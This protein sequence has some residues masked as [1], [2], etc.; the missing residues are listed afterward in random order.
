IDKS[1]VADI[2][3]PGARGRDAGGGTA[4][5]SAVIGLARGLGLEVIAEGVEKRAQYDFLT[6]AGCTA[7]QGY[8][9]CPPVPAD[10]FERWLKARQKKRNTEDTEKSRR[11][12]RK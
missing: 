4:I 3:H 1:F 6:R 7:C 2:G 9:I 11:T 10:E 8:L 5:A 12:R